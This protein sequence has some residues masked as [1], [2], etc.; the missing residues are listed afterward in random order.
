MIDKYK[1]E[2]PLREAAA[3]AQKEIEAQVNEV[4]AEVEKL[5]DSSGNI[6]ERYFVAGTKALHAMLAD[7]YAAY[8]TVERSELRD[9]LV[10]K[11]K[12][13]L[14]VLDQFE[15]RANSTLTGLFVR[16]VFKGVDAKQIHVYGCALA[17]AFHNNVTV[18]DFDAFVKREGGL[19]AIRVKVA[20]RKKTSEEGVRADLS[21]IMLCNLRADD[22]LALLNEEVV[23]M[24]GNYI[25]LLGVKNEDGTVSVHEMPLLEA[26]EEKVMAIAGKVFLEKKIGKVRRRAMTKQEKEQRLLADGAVHNQEM[27]VG[28]LE[29]RIRQA[30]QGKNDEDIDMLRAKL[31]LAVPTLKALKAAFK[32]FKQQL[33]EKREVK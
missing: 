11:L 30:E 23:E 28:D 22:A 25:V 16:F 24:D 17:Y 7:A 21:E 8:V 4:F 3:A 19:E 32:E 1:A 13:R 20:A 31:A 15:E 10:T 18:D 27:I 33:K 26:D 5:R 6:V 14:Y 29:A 9:N 12:N 2:A